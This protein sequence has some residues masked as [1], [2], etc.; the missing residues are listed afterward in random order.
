[1]FVL[2]SYL[3][4]SPISPRIADCGSSLASSPAMRILRPEI[5]TGLERPRHLRAIRRVIVGLFAS[6]MP[7]DTNEYYGVH[8]YR[9]AVRGIKDIR[10]GDNM[11]HDYKRCG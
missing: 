5:C 4:T 3:E 11:T 8:V 1:M 7:V 9:V 2:L 6:T 10:M